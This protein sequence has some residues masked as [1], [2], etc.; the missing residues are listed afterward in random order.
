MP[1]LQP[2]GHRPTSCV[3]GHLQWRE[4]I[5]HN[6]PASS[7]VFSLIMVVCRTPKNPQSPCVF[8]HPRGQWGPCT[9]TEQCAWWSMTCEVGILLRLFPFQL[10]PWGKGDLP[11][12]HV[13][14][15]SYC[16]AFTFITSTLLAPTMPDYIRD[17]GERASMQW[18]CHLQRPYP[19][20]GFSVNLK[21]KETCRG[22]RMFRKP[23]EQFCKCLQ[24][25]GER[26]FPFR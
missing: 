14:V 19:S 3:A 9:G 23:V 11:L 4:G 6:H 18:R 25:V 2:C 22:G 13:S 26:C 21:A 12:G 24:W 20:P 10:L 17:G 7:L 1:P 5:L 15:Q 8:A 16:W